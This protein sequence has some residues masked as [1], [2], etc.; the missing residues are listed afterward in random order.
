MN[1][2]LQPQF[3]FKIHRATLTKYFDREAE[4]LPRER[5]E[6]LQLKRLGA[7]LENAW[8]NVALHREQSHAQIRVH[9]HRRAA[10]IALDEAAD[11]DDDIA[12]V[13]D[14]IHRIA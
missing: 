1:A 4:T 8:E 10:I 6:A 2:M 11:P 9:D 5:L 7:S 14:R 3:H 12:V 13:R